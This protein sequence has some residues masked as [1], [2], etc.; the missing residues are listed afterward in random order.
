MIL[1]PLL[2]LGKTWKGLG[3]VWK[4]V[5]SGTESFIIIF[6]PINAMWM[7]S[8]CTFSGCLMNKTLEK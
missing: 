7:H 5:I 8:L 6:R 3:Y 1:C 4:Y 2:A